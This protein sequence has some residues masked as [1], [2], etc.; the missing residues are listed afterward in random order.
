MPK[1]LSERLIEQQD[2]RNNAIKKTKKPQRERIRKSAKSVFAC[3]TCDRKVTIRW[4]DLTD[5][6]PICKECG[7]KLTLMTAC[8]NKGVI[9]RAS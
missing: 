3:N 8:I 6:D 2:F 7:A 9:P 1:P 5:G 4:E